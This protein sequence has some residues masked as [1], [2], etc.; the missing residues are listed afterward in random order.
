MNNHKDFI[1]SS[2]AD[3]LK[4]VVSANAGIGNGIETYPLG[5]YVMPSV[6]LKMTG[7]QEQ[8]MKCICWEL[9]TKD[10]EYRY[11]RYKLKP[12]GE[13]STYDEKKIIYK[14]LIEQIKKYIPAFN[15]SVFLDKELIKMTTLSEII[16][17][18]SSTNL[19]TWSQKNFIEFV[20]NSTII[21]TNHFGSADNLLENVLQD[22][23]S[24]LYLH[25]NRCAHNTLSY[26]QNVPTLR[27]LM[28]ENYRYD[29]YFVRFTL[30]ILLD[31]IFVKLYQKYTGLLD[32]D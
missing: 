5:D 22:K 7:F 2:I 25:R 23:Y 18:F 4:D 30:L 17:I 21:Q 11:R 24:L 19:S 29:N 3:I 8:K 20:S 9:A 31:K 26:Q 15:V 27:T 14:D 13:C 12:L 6:F 32:L 10:Y 28:N 16:N 1:L